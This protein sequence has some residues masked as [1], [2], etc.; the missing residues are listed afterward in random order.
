MA[1]EAALAVVL[2]VGSGLLARDL[3]RISA[4]EPGFRPEGLASMR[5]N[6]SPRYPRDEWV[7][8]WERF[9][10]GARGVPGV[11][12]AAVAT[13]VPFGGDRIVS[14]YRA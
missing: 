3:M 1:V 11:T 12:A 6:L 2:A 5:I 4:D 14:T 10:D 7:G 9:L 8:M 13:Q